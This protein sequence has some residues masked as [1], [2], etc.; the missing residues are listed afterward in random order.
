MGEGLGRVTLVVIFSDHSRRALRVVE[1]LLFQ[2]Y[3]TRY[4]SPSRSRVRVVAPS[5]EDSCWPPSISTINLAS[6][7]A[8]SAIRSASDGE[9]GTLLFAATTTSARTLS[10]LQSCRAEAFGLTGGRPRW[11]ASSSQI[12][13]RWPRPYPGP[14]HQGEDPP[15]AAHRCEYQRSG[16]EKRDRRRFRNNRRGQELGH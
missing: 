2:N 13:P 9:A 16:T 15:A 4:P 12:C 6:W 8:K 10:K 5:D 7:Q 1:R 3:N 11:V 14:P